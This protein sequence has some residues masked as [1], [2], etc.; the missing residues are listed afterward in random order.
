LAVANRQ[1]EE[2]DRIFTEFGVTHTFET[3]EEDHTN[4]VIEPIEMKVLPFFSNS[5]SFSAPT[6]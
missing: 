6:K 5:R 3:Y 4:H 2:M 1:V